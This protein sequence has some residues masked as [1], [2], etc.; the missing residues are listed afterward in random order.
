MQRMSLFVHRKQL[1]REPA[2]FRHELAL[3]QVHLQVVKTYYASVPRVVVHS[4]VRLVLLR[5]QD[6]SRSLVPLAKVGQCQ[7]PAVRL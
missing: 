4:W 2:H 1:H 3:A 5:Q 6:V 7:P